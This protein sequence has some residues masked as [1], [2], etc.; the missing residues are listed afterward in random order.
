MKKR[1]FS[2]QKALALSVLLLFTVVMTGCKPQTEIQ[3]VYYYVTPLENGDPL[4][5]DWFNPMYA[6]KITITQNSIDAKSTE[7]KIELKDSGIKEITVTDNGNGMDKDKFIDNYA[8][9]NLCVMKLSDTEGIFFI[10]YTRA[11]K[12]DWSGYSTNPSE[13]PDVG[14][15]YAVSYKNFDSTNKTIQIAG[16]YNAARKSSCDSLIE[17]VQEFTIENGYFSTYDDFQ[18]Y[19]GE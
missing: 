11:G 14:K 3:E 18:L 10:K 5:Q 4:I 6:Q 8:G 2:L 19:D 1:F 16:A 13:A 9:N 15:W 17:A 12:P 7:I